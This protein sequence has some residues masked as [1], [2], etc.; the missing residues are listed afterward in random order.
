MKALPALVALLFAP[1]LTAPEGGTQELRDEPFEPPR[2]APASPVPARGPSWR[3]LWIVRVALGALDRVAWVVV[4][5]GMTANFVTLA[6]L[7][8]AALGGTLVGLGEFAWATGLVVIASLGDALDGLVA[9]RSGAASIGGALLDSASDR[10]GE[11]FLLGGMAVHFRGSAGPLV[12]TLGAL[13]GSFM[14]SYG[15]AKAE[16]L[17]VAVPAGA[18]RRPERAVCLCCGLGL[19]AGLT[20]LA[21][22]GWFAPR[23][24]DVPVL[25]AVGL[26]AAVGNAS[27]IGRLRRLAGSPSLALKLPV[28]PEPDRVRAHSRSLTN[29]GGFR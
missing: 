10:Y 29:H 16:A 13:A 5:L 2:N 17:G 23:T 26:V 11:M 22:A 21:N 4:A 25:I 7:G 28:S 18:M 15:S 20:A 19:T 14:V 12:L 24:A 9:R 3:S 27:A 8:L 6:S 1:P